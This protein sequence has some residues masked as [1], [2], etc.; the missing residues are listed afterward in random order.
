MFL[1]FLERVPI[2]MVSIVP[3]QILHCAAFDF[4][5]GI[6]QRLWCPA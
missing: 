3:A 2:D 6:L 5:P 1:P 4:V